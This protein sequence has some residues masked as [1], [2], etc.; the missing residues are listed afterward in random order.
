MEWR[1]RL[2][3]TGATCCVILSANAHLAKYQSEGKEESEIKQQKKVLVDC[4]QMIPDCQKRLQ[5]ATEDLQSILDG[6]QQD[7][8]VSSTEEAKAA[9]EV[10]S[11][12]LAAVESK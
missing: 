6:L 5:S 4:Q 3:S 10:L 12:A 9:K 2:S 8:E 7:E 11:S 1:V